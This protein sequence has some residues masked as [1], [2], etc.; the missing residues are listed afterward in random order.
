MSEKRLAS[1]FATSQEF[2]K[3]LEKNHRTK[4]ELW[5]GFCKKNIGGSQHHLTSIGGRSAWLWVD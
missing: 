3:W 2:R 5:V 1:F 4:Q